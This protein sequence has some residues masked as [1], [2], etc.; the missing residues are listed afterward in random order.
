VEDSLEQGFATV[1]Q[2]HLAALYRAALRL[3]RRRHD[4]EDLVQDVCLRA[5]TRLDDLAAMANPRAW[6]MRALYHCFVD[7]TRRRRC[8]PHSSLPDDE[9]PGAPV[10][11]EPGPERAADARRLHERLAAVWHRL[12]AEQRALLSL[13]AEGNDL[14]ELAAI[15]GVNRNALSARLHRARQRLAKLLVA[16]EPAPSLH[17][18]ETER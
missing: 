14:E 5:C 6:L 17:L 10:S 16:G 3:T 8:R 15:F 12:D 7:A 2:P 9:A 1:V 13:H 18:V 4:A 11:D